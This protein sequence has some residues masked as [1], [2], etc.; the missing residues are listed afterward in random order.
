MHKN[1]YLMIFVYQNWYK[2]HN[3]RPLI[4]D[5]K[6]IKSCT[7]DNQANLQINQQTN[8]AISTIDQPITNS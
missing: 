7:I 2:K 3:N 8:A 6:P 5:I 4:V 1:L